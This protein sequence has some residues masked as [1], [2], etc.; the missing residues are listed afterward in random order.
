MNLRLF[1]NNPSYYNEMDVNNLLNYPG[2][3]DTCL[4]VPSLEEIANSIGK[5]NVDDEVVDDTILLEPITHKEILI[6]FTT[7]HIL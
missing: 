6:A 3:S 5:I 1:T 4:E 2:E 7:I